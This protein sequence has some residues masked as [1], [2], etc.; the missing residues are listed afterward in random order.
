MFPRVVIERPAGCLKSG[1]LVSFTSPASPPS[2][3]T[4][5]SFSYFL[6]QL[7]LAVLTP[8]PPTVGAVNGR[9]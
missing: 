3:G 9:L 7:F 2:S 8:L 1:S 5:Y 4:G 6:S